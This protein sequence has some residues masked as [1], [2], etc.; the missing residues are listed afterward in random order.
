MKIFCISIFSAMVLALLASCACGSLNSDVSF[1][2]LTKQE[3]AYI[4]ST[5]KGNGEVMI[6]SYGKSTI[7]G[8]QGSSAI[9][10][11]F[12]W[13]KLKTFFKDD[14]GN[15]Y[16]LL[17]IYTVM[18]LVP[19]FVGTDGTIYDKEGRWVNTHH[20]SGVPLLY[21][22]TQLTSRNDRIPAGRDKDWQFDLVDI[23]YIN[24]LIGF[25]NSY[26]QFL[27]IPLVSQDPYRSPKD[28]LNLD[29]TPGNDF[30]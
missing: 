26:F 18:P 28:N 23:P 16:G 17:T 13:L 11:T 24:G 7:K 5:P 8:S 1:P 19:L 6:Q 10:P 12:P 2:E 9:Y 14:K 30:K 20:C 21:T 4:E 15:G 29:Y 22:Y 27:W 3:I 25:G